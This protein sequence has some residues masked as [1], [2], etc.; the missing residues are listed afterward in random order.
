MRILEMSY[1]IKILELNCGFQLIQSSTKTVMQSR[2]LLTTPGCCTSDASNANFGNR[3]LLRR[4]TSFSGCSYSYTGA[5]LL[6]QG[7]MSALFLRH[8]GFLG[9][10]GAFLKVHPMHVPTASSVAAGHA[11]AAAA[12]AADG[13]SVARQDSR[14]L[15]ESASTKVR[16]VASSFVPNNMQQPALLCIV[17]LALCNQ[18]VAIISV[19]CVPD[20]SCDSLCPSCAERPRCLRSFTCVGV[21]Q[22]RARFVERFSMG[23]PFAGGE[24]H[25]PAIRDMSDRVSW[26]EKFVAVGCQAQ[27]QAQQRAAASAASMQVWC[28]GSCVV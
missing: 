23:A 22:V 8:E 10:V 20:I 14:V 7:E 3:L 27:Q 11:R 21:L 1:G 5:L 9:A 28:G 15:H 24:V 6:L 4:A 17:L 26:V 2:T 25:G 16:W 12:N 13:S 19:A 18:H